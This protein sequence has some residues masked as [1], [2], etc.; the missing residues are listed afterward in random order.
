[1]RVSVSASIARPPLRA[2]VYL[3]TS[4]VAAAAD[5]S[6]EGVARLIRLGLIEPREPGTSEFTVETAARL[7]R[8]LRLRRDLHV[9]LIGATIILELL[10]RIDRMESELA[11]RSA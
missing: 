5:L 10:D 11:R 9:N 4:Q 8:M 3:T 7:R 1:V 2:E 6:P